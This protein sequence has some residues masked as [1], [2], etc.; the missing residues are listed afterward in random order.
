MGKIGQYLTITKRNKRGM[1][2]MNI[3]SYA[4]D[5][6]STAVF[7]GVNHVQEGEAINASFSASYITCIHKSS[8]LNFWL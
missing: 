3:T 2:Q 8:R 7:V 6:V 5:R 4:S 1:L